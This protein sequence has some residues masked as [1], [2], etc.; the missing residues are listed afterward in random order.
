M[1]GWTRLYAR[2]TESEHLTEVLDQ[3]ADAFALFML[4]MAKAGVWGRFPANPKLLKARVAPLSERLTPARIAE[5]LPI[6]EEP[7]PG[8]QGGLVQRYTVDDRGTA[9]LAITKHLDYNA[10]QQ[11]HRVGRPEFPPPPGWQPPPALCVYLEKVRQ[12]RYRDKTFGHECARFGLRPE[13]IRHGAPVPPP[14]EAPPAP[15]VELPLASEA[16]GAA[17]ETA[18]AEPEALTPEPEAAPE[19]KRRQRRAKPVDDRATGHAEL[20]DALEAAYPNYREARL[21]G[22]LAVYLGHLSQPGCTVNEAQL[23]AALKR[24]PPLAG[25]SPDR[26]MLHAQSMFR[27][28][29]G[30]E[31]TAARPGFTPEQV[32]EMEQR[33]TARVDAQL[34]EAR[35]QR[36]AEFGIPPEVDEWWLEAQRLMQ[37]R[38][39]WSF[40]LS[41]CWLQSVAGGVATLL[42]P[43]SA[44]SR[45]APLEG[46]IVAA[47]QEVVGGPVS[48]DVREIAGA[49]AGREDKRRAEAVEQARAYVDDC[50][51][52]ADDP[53]ALA[54]A[55]KEMFGPDLAR[56][57][58]R[59]VTGAADDD[60]DQQRW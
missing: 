20:Y 60:E 13:A 22:L 29:A 51:A 7:P 24:D 37:E 2:A 3:D 9:C 45:V 15:Q 6:L 23:V 4:M 11:W 53:E 46:E 39:S 54:D 17:D 30:N 19:P 25:S 49:G 16:D 10:R 40:G 38:E 27:E 52:Y 12:G 31:E 50:E 48:L 33:H 57:A 35:L 32:A 26:Y 14:D 55:L 5:V 1:D 36:L 56:L 47:L 18:I 21:R 43:A 41:M 34:Q 28:A 59:E 8:E 44:R 58:A 42:V